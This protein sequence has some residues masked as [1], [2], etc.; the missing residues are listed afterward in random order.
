MTILV[1]EPPFIEPGLPRPEVF[2]LAALL[3][4]HGADARVVDANLLVYQGLLGDARSGSLSEVPEATLRDAFCE[5]F[6]VT[7]SDLQRAIDGDCSR[8]GDMSPEVL[9]ALRERD[10]SRLTPALQS[11]SERFSGKGIFTSHQQYVADQELMNAALDAQMRALAPR[12]GWQL[13]LSRVESA[14]VV[15]EPEGVLEIA[16]DRGGPVAKLLDRHVR[17]ALTSDS[18][19]AALVVIGQESQLVGGLAL[20]AWL[21]REYSIRATATGWHLLQV[22]QQHWP[23]ALHEVV[24]E[25]AVHPLDCCVRE[26]LGHDDH[27]YVRCSPPPTFPSLDL[28]EVPQGTR[29]AARM[30]GCVVEQ[31]SEAYLSPLPITGAIATSRCYWSRCAFCG[32]AA[33]RA[34]PLRH[35]PAEDIVSAFDRLAASGVHHLQFFD[36]ALPPRLLQEL[37]EAGDRGV[38]WC[39]QARFEPAFL[40][41]GFFNRLAQAGCVG[42]SWG[43]ETAS[44]RLLER[45]GK[46]GVVEPHQ[47]AAILRNSTRAGLQN[48]LFAI[49]G[50]PGE[51]EH[52]FLESAGWIA[53]N[54]ENIAGLEPYAYQLHAR[55]AFDEQ[56]KRWGLE[57]GAGASGWLL[58]FPFSSPISAAEVRWRLDV[59]S[60]LAKQIA[61]C[62]RT[63]D[64]MEGHLTLGRALGVW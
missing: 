12:G 38:C 60:S 62:R 63:H 20:A 31:N 11:V 39:G 44:P 59:L 15:A 18:V 34:L 26:W 2:R 27:P 47:R 42:I 32:I 46:G 33:T 48:Y 19:Q 30:S 61:I 56:R 41:P 5:A 22:L 52:E 9:A 24:P 28:A 54:A 3:R 17:S 55:T 36:Y 7:K 51:T 6:F 1:F 21:W 64:W 10:I 4:G 8:A 45:I 40:R 16:S 53:D 29:R 35:L 58:N 13:W 50:L 43:F 14:M 23:R 49:V 37:A 25:I 57:V